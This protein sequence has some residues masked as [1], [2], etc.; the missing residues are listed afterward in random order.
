MLT[1]YDRLLELDPANEKTI[2]GL[3][4]CLNQYID[5]LMEAKRYE[6]IRA[7][8]EKY[9]DVAVNVDFAA[10]LAKIADLEKVEAE[11]R[12]F[13]QKV[14]D[15]M[16]A[17]DYEEGMYAVDGSEEANVF[18]ARMDGDHYIYFPEGDGS[19][20]GVGAGV[21]SY[22]DGG[23]YFYY[24]DYVDG[25]RKGTGNVFQKMAEGY[26]AFSG[27]WDND[28]PN[29]AGTAIRVGGMSRGNGWRYDKVKSGTLKDGLWDG[30]VNVILTNSSNNRDFDLSFNA[31]RGV[32]A[33]DKTEEFLAE[34]LYAEGSEDGQYIYAYDYQPDIMEWWW[35]SAKEGATTGT[36][37]FADIAN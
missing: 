23:Y 10:I 31:V 3:C 26:Y 1:V 29:G 36:P 13:M 18:V 19:L 16:A 5:I 28:A 15:L 2:E 12:T 11:N 20:S 6:D 8:A 37:G 30:Q 32:P 34:G 4:N 25:K 35:S 27:T 22:G 14:Y 17:K 24:G 7:L 33:E 21:Y 9:G